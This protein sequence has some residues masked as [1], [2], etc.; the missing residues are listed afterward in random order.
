MT[1]ARPSP[2]SVTTQS[3]AQPAGTSTISVAHLS[4]LRGFTL[5]Q[6]DD[7]LKNIRT[8][9]LLKIITP[10][11]RIS[12]TFIAAELNVSAPEVEQLLVA[13]ILD[14]Q[15]DGQIDQLAQLLLLRQSS[16]NAKKY[17]AAEKWAK[18][19]E[20]LQQTILTKLA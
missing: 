10:Y 18:Q 2:R 3:I 11:T 1:S 6:I 8:Q 13:L 17:A 20:T 12:I 5:D 16:A 15:I 19:L 14:G 9:V 7:L 4:S